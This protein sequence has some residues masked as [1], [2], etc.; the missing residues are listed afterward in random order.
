MTCGTMITRRQFLRA[1]AAAAG[2]GL[3]M[4]LYTWRW[5][6]HWLDVVERRLRVAN[7]PDRLAGARLAQL[8][9]LHI[10]PRVDDSYLIRSFERVKAL[11]PEIVVY[12]GD[13]TSYDE[14]DVFVH[15]RRVFAHLP[16]GSRATLGILGNHDYGPGWAHPEIADR[17]AALAT[18]AGVR[19]LRNEM[20]EVEGLQVVGLD[21]LWA[22]RFEP[23]RALAALDPRSASLVLSHNP[24]TADQPGWGEYAGWILAGHTHGGQCKPPFLPPPSLP[25]LNRRY[26]SG[27]FELSG[28]RRLYINRGVGHLLRL[29]FNARPEITVFQLERA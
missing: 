8:S 25:V 19:V 29:R 21:D 4:G 12:T 16:L 5:E 7:L 6:P 27:E 18:A 11:A 10:G 24:D 22:R 26:T 13:F 3:G 15:A 17:I 14:A 9:D 2:V 1:S 23:K 20:A 28:G